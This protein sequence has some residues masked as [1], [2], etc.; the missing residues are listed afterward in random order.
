MTKWWG[1][2]FRE[3]HGGA[4][5]RFDRYP[6]DA[7]FLWLQPVDLSRMN[8]SWQPLEHGALDARR[9]LDD[10]SRLDEFIDKLPDPW[11]DPQF[12]SLSREAERLHADNRYI[13]VAWWR[14]FFERPWAL[15]GMENL[16]LDYALAPEQ[17]HRLHEA[18]CRQYCSYLERAAATIAPDGFWTSDDL[19][20]QTGAMFS[21]GTFE[22]MLKPYYARVGTTLRRHGMH[23]WLH[24]CGDNT[25][26]LPQLIDAGVDVLHPVQK[27]AMN[28]GAVAARYAD[29]LTFCAGMDVQHILPRGTEAEVRR[30]VRGL[31]DIFDRPDGGLCLAAGNGILPGTP[32]ENIDAFLEEALLQGTAHR[33]LQR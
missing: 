13:I 14:L 17:V 10:W 24:S 8:L 18:L 11:A 21:P 9:A 33:A 28:A 29:S 23:W 32:L 30:E 19:G 20:H 16:L 6:D 1:E 12:D 26:L 7:A 15:R 5:R 2:G 27:G 4:L 3:L 25:P 31:I 22:S